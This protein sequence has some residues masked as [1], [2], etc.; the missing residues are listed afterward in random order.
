M[1][2]Q[3]RTPSWPDEQLCNS[4]FYTAMRT[5]GICP[6]CG[7]DGVLP[8]RTNRTDSRPVC[9]ACAGIPKNYR[10]T[11]CDIEGQIYRGGQCARC[12]LRDD[13]TALMVVGA[14]DPVIMGT[15]VDILC[16]VDRPE[17]ILTWKRSPIVRALLTGLAGGDIPLSHD[18]LDAAGQGRQVS[19]LRS[20]LEHNGLLPHRDEHLA[21][22]QC[23]LDSKLDAICGRPY[24][25]Q[26]NSSPPGII[27]NVYV[28]TRRQGKPPMAQTHSAQQEITE[29][30]KFL[31]WLHEHHH[32]TAASCRQQDVDE[33][34]ATGPTTRTKIRTFFAWTNKSKINTAV[35]LENRQART[36]RLLTQDQRLAW[37]HGLL[38]GDIE[39]LPYRVAGTLLLLYAQPLVRIVALKTTAVDVTDDE[40]R[41]S[42]GAAPAPVPVPFADMLHRPL[43]Q[44]DQPSNRRRNG[45]QPV[46]LSRP[47]RRQAPRSTNHDDE[48]SHS[49]HRRA[50]RTKLRS[51]EP[52]R[53]DTSS[54]R[55]KPVG[56]Q[57]HL[58]PIP[59]P[60][61]GA[62]LGALRHL[63]VAKSS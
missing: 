24:E 23:W 45:F 9:L 26:S 63:A 58:Y 39:S 54:R 11:T 2:T 27:C 43:G 31:T 3:D 37:I 53:R 1:S 61:R 57:P 46:A 28:E 6:I 21:R 7:H 33:W 22:F 16:G 59:C 5:R 55:S 38:T 49:R 44:P 30:I 40:M 35:R 52:R 42:L 29:T 41:I 48:A 20:L 56:L 15:I 51:A 62:A 19:H 18:G 34:L 17:S 12:A 14:A 50:R 36:I 25:H 4:C 60:T 32:R 13:L 47:Q 10:C 8:G